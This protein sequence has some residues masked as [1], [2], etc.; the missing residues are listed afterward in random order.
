MTSNNPLNLSEDEKKVIE[1][2]ISSIR[3]VLRNHNVD[4][5]S[6]VGQVTSADLQD[7]RS[8]VEVRLAEDTVLHVVMNMIAMD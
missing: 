1:T 4:V 5:K 8:A 6:I 3:K 7:S 2:S